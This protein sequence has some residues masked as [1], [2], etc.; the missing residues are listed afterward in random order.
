MNHDSHSGVCNRASEEVAFQI[1]FKN[2]FN[3][4]KSNGGASMAGKSQR[5]NAPVHIICFVHNFDY[6]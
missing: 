1:W 6:F 3:D 2:K 4:R 5:V